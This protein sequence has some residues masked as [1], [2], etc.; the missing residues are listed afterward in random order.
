MERMTVRRHRCA[1]LFGLMCLAAA[2]FAALACGGDNAGADDEVVSPAVDA[3]ARVGSTGE[4]GPC[5]DAV[6]AARTQCQTLSTAD[7]VRCEAGLDE[8]VAA[9]REAAHL[10]HGECD[11]LTSDAAQSACSLAMA[12]TATPAATDPPTAQAATAT[13]VATPQAA[14]VPA[15]ARALL[16]CGIS[17]ATG[18]D[19][20]DAECARALEEAEKVCDGL[21]GASRDACRGMLDGFST[22]G[23]SSNS[24]AGN[25]GTDPNGQSGQQGNA[26]QKEK[27]GNGGDGGGRDRKTD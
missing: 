16:T 10:L 2:C 6:S 25:S 17:G 19:G 12:I 9:A 22:S 24:G 8:L 1:T 13:P 27:P 15:F 7:R 14:S 20:D 21:S 23:A 11:Q 5:E 4:L 3:C 18:D 26:G